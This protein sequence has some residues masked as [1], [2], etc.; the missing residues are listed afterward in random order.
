ME[1]IIYIYF[2]LL[3]YFERRKFPEYD[4]KMHAFV[5]TLIPICFN[6]IAISGII[7]SNW[8]P[9]INLQRKHFTFFWEKRINGF[10]IFAPTAL[11]CYIILKIKK[12]YI[13]QKFNSF[14]N[15]EVPNLK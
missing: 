10:L 4:Q 7:K 1:T 8:F 5:I 3:K 11:I 14:N 6:V 12:K 15:N 9:D 13:E 2:R